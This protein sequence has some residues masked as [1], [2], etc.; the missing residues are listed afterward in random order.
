MSYVNKYYSYI[1]SS[2]IDISL[3]V[4]TT[5]SSFVPQY[6]N[7]PPVISSTSSEY[8]YQPASAG[9]GAIRFNYKV[10]DYDLINKCGAYTKI[11]DY[12]NAPL[13]QPF[14]FNIPNYFNKMA[15]VV[16]G[17]GGGGGASKSNDSG[18]AGG[19]GGSGGSAGYVLYNLNKIYKYTITCTIASGGIGGNRST[20]TWANGSPGNTSVLQF[21]S[22]NY[23][24]ATGGNG[25]NNGDANSAPRGNANQGLGG[26]KGGAGYSSGGMAFPATYNGLDGSASSPIGNPPYWSSGGVATNYTGASKYIPLTMSRTGQSMT[27]GYSNPYYGC[28]G[29]GGMGNSDNG[30]GSAPSYDGGVGGG[31]YIQVWFYI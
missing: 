22:S 26:N 9:N 12:A 14:T 10:G 21:D 17:G 24:Y 19:G 13:N 8:E 5:L 28:S 23:M 18:G 25:G 3:L 1:D 2:S 30:S 31:G 15:A 7:F 16:I 11:W 27:V 20:P 6:V 29:G 4:D